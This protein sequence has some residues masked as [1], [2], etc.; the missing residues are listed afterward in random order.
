MV[1]VKKLSELDLDNVLE[2]EYGYAK[3]RRDTQ[4][5]KA[6][7]KLLDTSYTHA[8]SEIGRCDVDTNGDVNFDG[9]KIIAVTKSGKFIM[10]FSSEWGGVGEEK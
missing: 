3:Y 2:F 10:F 1:T 6:L 9:G 8:F 7:N 5:R 4:V